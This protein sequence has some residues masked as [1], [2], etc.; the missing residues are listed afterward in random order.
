LAELGYG[1]WALV[2]GRLIVA[3]LE[4]G[5]MFYLSGFRPKLHFDKTHTKEL[6]HFCLPLSGAAILTMTQKRAAILFTGLVL[7]PT[8][9]ALLNAAKKGEQ[10]ISQITM[11][12][13][14]SM[15]V[16]SF[17]RAKEGQI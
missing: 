13:I 4:L 14:N 15:V 7:G 6:V 2:T 17:A 1:L 11:S 3:V 5:F 8:S 16:P 10:M 12:S 9:F